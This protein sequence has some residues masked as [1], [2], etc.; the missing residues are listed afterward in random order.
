MSANRCDIAVGRS[1]ELTAEYI[2]TVLNSVLFYRGVY[3]PE[4]FA[5]VP[6]R[7]VKADASARIRKQPTTPVLE[8]AEGKAYMRDV[9]GDVIDLLSA[10]L[11]S[12]VVLQVVDDHDA[13]I[14]TWCIDVNSDAEEIRRAEARG[15]AYSFK[16]GESTME[17]C[18]LALQQLVE[19]VMY[20]PPDPS[21]CSFRL[22]VRSSEAPNEDWHPDGTPLEEDTKEVCLKPIATSFITVSVAL[23]I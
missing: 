19:T 4:Y 8:Q 7:L 15:K 21:A 12:T 11:L 2:G 13:V 22:F 16:S 6:C 5:Q 20:L 23:A 3:P 10:S 9:L 18:Q 1:L 14:E 17:E